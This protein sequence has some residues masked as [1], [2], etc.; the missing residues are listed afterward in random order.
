MKLDELKKKAGAILDKARADVNDSFRQK[1]GW[2]GLKDCILGVVEHVE[3]EGIESGL[4]G[5]DK[6]LLAVEV[7]LSL[8][9]FV[10]PPAWT[11][12][13]PDWALRMVLGYLVDRA[14][15]LKNK[16]WKKK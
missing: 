15:A 1:G 6:K 16:V 14:V 7:A 11:K 12:F 8:V 4:A 3:A 13:L 10:L 9:R 2:P 5:P